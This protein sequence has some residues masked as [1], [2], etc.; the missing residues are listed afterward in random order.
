M[1]KNKGERK[2]IEGQKIQGNLKTKST[3]KSDP[4]STLMIVF[5]NRKKTK[6]ERKKTRGERKKM[7]GK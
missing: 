7:R 4:A 2:Q 6:G 5:E 3:I 1:E